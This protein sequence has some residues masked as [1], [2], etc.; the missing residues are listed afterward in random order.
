MPEGAEFFGVG[1]VSCPDGRVCFAVGSFSTP[2]IGF[3]T[4]V[5]RRVGSRWSV[6]PTP[7]RRHPAQ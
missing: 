5:E 3:A 7:N 4:L 1:G 2:T 6:M